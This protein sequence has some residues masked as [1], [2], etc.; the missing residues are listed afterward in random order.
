LS[1]LGG[2][3]TSGDLSTA[4]SAFATVL[5][6]LKNS[7]SAAQVI[8]ATAASQSVQL[9]EGLLDT[10]NA[11]VSST[12]STDNTTSILQSVYAGK[13]GLNVFA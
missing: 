2:A 13:S 10:L 5:G 11:S 1:A 9:I 4:Q 8:E 12:G 6:D 3:L 7:A